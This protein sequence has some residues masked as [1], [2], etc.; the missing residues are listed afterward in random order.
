VIQPEKQYIS[1]L[2]L[3]MPKLRLAVIGC[4]FWSTFQIS[5]WREFSDDIQL[6]AVCDKDAG[7]AKAT[8]ERFGVPAAYAD[9]EE[10]LRRERP[11]VVDIITDVDTHA[12]FVD[13]AAGYGA[14]VVCQKPMAPDLATAQ[15]MVATCREKGV[16]FYVH[17]NFRW[18]APIRRLKAV[19]DSG[20]IGRVFKARVWF[21]SAFPVFDNQ[22]FL[23][24]LEQFIL[25][26]IGS[27]VLDT[28]RFLFGEVRTLHCLTQRVNPRIKG[29]DVAN[30]L[31]EM[32]D[33]THCY[34]EM[35]YASLLEK[36]VFPQT[37]VLAEGTAGSVHLDADFVLKTVTRAGTRAETVR[38]TLYDWID[39]AYAV[40]HSSLV[41]CIGN[42]VDEL[43]GRGR[44]ETVGDDNLKTAQL[45]FAC[46]DSARNGKI[47]NFEVRDGKPETGDRQ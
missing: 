44:A 12:R 24:Q 43:R 42:L 23:A 30:V 1:G 32:T 36:E 38:P 40:V 6:A 11:D 14:A 35:S 46:Y 13:M 39:P 31:L 21:C 22:P 41:A 19:L 3:R 5:A 26:D 16:R 18:Q 33:G 45:V 15:R 7:R 34:T 20:E 8:A 9:A 25:T 2:P 4:G 47:I 10:M 29:E 28:V 37:L 17:E 27:H